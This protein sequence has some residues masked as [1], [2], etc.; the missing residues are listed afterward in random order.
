MLKTAENMRGKSA[1]LYR[2]TGHPGH[3]LHIFLNSA[4]EQKVT[5][6]SPPAISAFFRVLDVLPRCSIANPE[7]LPN[8]MNR[9]AFRSECHNL[10]LESLGKGRT[11][12]ALS[13][14]LG[15]RH[16][17]FHALT[18]QGTLKLGERRHHRKNP[19]F[20]DF[21]GQVPP[22]PRLSCNDEAVSSSVV[23]HG[24]DHVP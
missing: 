9:Q 16:P 11:G 2:V 22:P 14:G 7:L 8:L 17:G 23:T 18:D 10:C 13:L 1:L 20:T 24:L 21:S 12:D 5:R 4:Y 15:P 3:R 6:C 19:H